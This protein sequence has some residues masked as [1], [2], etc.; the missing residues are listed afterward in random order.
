MQDGP[1]RHL[2]NKLPS[3]ASKVISTEK[4]PK[5]NPAGSFS[6][7]TKIE[8][9]FYDNRQKY[10]L[11]VNTCS[12][13]LETSNVVEREF[14]HIRPTPPAI[15][16]FDAGM[17]DGT[18]LTR[19]LRSMH[20][21]RLTIITVSLALL[22]LG[23]SVLASNH[24]LAQVCTPVSGTTVTI[25]ESCSDLEISGDGSNEIGRASCRERV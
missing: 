1:E 18:A 9:R 24:A 21:K 15:R 16:L 8:F 20:S 11:F 3:K 23:F 5:Q 10:L 14:Q 12:E 22:A 4:G 13:K 17:G 6:M 19:V 25:T 2:E 7:A